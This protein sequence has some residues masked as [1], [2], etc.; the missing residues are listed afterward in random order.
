MIDIGDGTVAFRCNDNL[1]MNQH[2]TMEHEHDFCDEPGICPAC[3]FHLQC[4]SLTPIA[5]KILGVRQ[6]S[7][8]YILKC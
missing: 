8:Y 4:G 3:K 1:Y 7:M 2:P 5:L 6:A